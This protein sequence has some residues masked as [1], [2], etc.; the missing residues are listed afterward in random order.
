MAV[1]YPDSAPVLGAI[2]V[3]ALE[4]MASRTAPTVASLNAGTAIDLSGALTADGWKPATTQGKT[5]RMRRLA[6][7]VDFERLTPASHTIPTLMWSEGDPQDPDTD[8]ADLM[9]EG[10]LLY[11]VE[12]LGPD[13]ED[14]FVAAE[15]V[16]SR[17]VRL[18][19]PYDIYDPTADNGEFLRGVEVEFVDNGPVT[20]VVAA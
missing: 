13:A 17:Y 10:A 9:V 7:K 6:S 11:I 4:T 20:G 3:I 12:R 5:T 2:K 18:G 19:V 14:D 16:K 8:I 15:I 1:V